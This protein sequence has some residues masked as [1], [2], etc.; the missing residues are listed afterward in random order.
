MHDS[1]LCASEFQIL[2]CFFFL[3][4]FVTQT[5]N[6]VFNMSLQQY[7]LPQTLFAWMRVRI[8][9]AV[10]TDGHSWSVTMGKHNSGTYNK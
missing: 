5:T 9:C 4:F 3:F 2:T 10:A 7:I 8:A 1:R 6:N